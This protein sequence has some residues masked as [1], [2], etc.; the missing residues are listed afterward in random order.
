MERQKQMAR[1]KSSAGHSVVKDTQHD[2][3]SKTALLQ[4][5]REL[6]SQKGKPSASSPNRFKKK[7][8]SVM[9]LTPLKM[10]I[11]DNGMTAAARRNIY[12]QARQFLAEYDKKEPTGGCVRK[13]RRSS[14]QAVFDGSVSHSRTT[15]IVQ[16]LQENVAEQRAV[17]EAMDEDELTKFKLDYSA[18]L[19]EAC[20]FAVELQRYSD[21]WNAAKD[22]SKTFKHINQCLNILKAL[23]QSS[24]DSIESLM[25]AR[26]LAESG[27]V[28]KSLIAS[29]AAETWVQC[30]CARFDC[31]LFFKGL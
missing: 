8:A 20:E 13:R 6:E 16:I 12:S 5:K 10:S 26:E 11:S 29:L 2:F 23:K 31:L 25:Q 9:R 17:R 7:A 15:R 24:D 1:R 22:V 21:E 28:S 30:Y 3:E 14:V 27:K 19:E 18:L 4:G